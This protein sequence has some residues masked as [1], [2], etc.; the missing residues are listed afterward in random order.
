MIFDIVQLDGTARPT[1]TDIFQSQMQSS[2][3]NAKLEAKARRSLSS[4]SHLCDLEKRPT[5]FGF[6]ICFELGKCH[7]R[8]AKLYLSL[9]M[10][11]CIW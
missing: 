10:G 7:C 9:I 1:S 4:L 8:W 5:S 6:E 2:K 11:D 3:P